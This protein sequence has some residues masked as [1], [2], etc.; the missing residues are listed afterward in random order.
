[1]QGA[2][3]GPADQRQA[4]PRCSHSQC[5]RS[6][7]GRKAAA[8]REVSTEHNDETDSL[9]SRIEAAG[10]PPGDFWS[11]QHRLRLLHLRGEHDHRHVRVVNF[12][13]S[14]DSIP[15]L[16]PSMHR[17]SQ[18]RAQLVSCSRPHALHAVLHLAILVLV[19]L[20][21]LDRAETAGFE[22]TE[23]VAEL[24]TLLAG[25]RRR[26]VR[27]LLQSTI[28][29]WSLQEVAASPRQSP[30]SGDSEDTEACA[31]HDADPLPHV[32]VIDDWDE[33]VKLTPRATTSRRKPISQSTAPRSGVR[34]GRKA[35][36]A[37]V[38][39]EK[40][41]LSSPLTTEAD[42]RK[43]SGHARLARE[44]DRFVGSPAEWVEVWSPKVKVTLLPYGVAECSHV[45]GQLEQCNLE[46]CHSG[47]K[48]PEC[49]KEK[50]YPKHPIDS[51]SLL[52]LPPLP[53]PVLTSSDQHHACGAA[54][55]KQDED[56]RVLRRALRAL[57]RPANC[58]RA[59]LM[60]YYHQ[61]S[62]LASE[63][64]KLALALSMA[65]MTNRTL[66]VAESRGWGYSDPAVCGNK[67]VTCHMHELNTRCREED[68]GDEAPDFLEGKC[69][70]MNDSLVTHAARVMRVNQTTIEQHKLSMYYKTVPA[71]FAARGLFWWRA[72]L[73]SFLFT[74]RAHM[75]GGPGP[76]F[77]LSV[78]IRHDNIAEADPIPTAAYI[79]Q[80]SVAARML[81]ASRTTN[82]T[83]APAP[84]ISVFVACDTP[85]TETEAWKLL[86][87]HNETW[88]GAPVEVSFEGARQRRQ[89]THSRR[90]THLETM[91]IFAALERLADADIF[92][93]KFSSGVSR[94][95]AELGCVRGRFRLKP[96]SVDR[97][98]GTTC[99]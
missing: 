80:I 5:W 17:S 62:G 71:R 69:C 45:R 89:G 19:L 43:G 93:G 64:H 42:G 6:T 31:G 91:E 72:Q 68:A 77:H 87:T 78:H 39:K 18:A 16:N 73:V 53:P 66:V 47:R 55:D 8:W 22:E 81:A 38:H 15:Q 63:L 67:T 41:H 46:G 56:V 83:D 61:S 11:L 49:H 48:Y 76:R 35:L 12:S 59:R 2:H 34:A 85:A 29:A 74:P 90:H 88:P 9:K 51:D 57:Q 37:R 75:R 40:R 3:T 20:P 28:E 70:W 86:R 79:N 30:Q 7:L 52:P 13:G 84:A 24:K 96:V 21:L 4:N 32:E 25:A 92:V 95:I 65:L 33:D 82:A 1:M 23:D 50:P 99:P 94:L 36:D 27:D 10:S 58:K 98:W 97:Q 60:V 26:R 54:F 44:A 14:S